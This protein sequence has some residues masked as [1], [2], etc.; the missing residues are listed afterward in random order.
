M[1]NEKHVEDADIPEL[2]KYLVVMNES[3]KI[4]LA[5]HQMRPDD[6]VVKKAHVQT[7]VRKAKIE[8]IIKTRVWEKI[9]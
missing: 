2:N 3:V 9:F 7:L 1:N 4:S 5:M 8:R 6:M